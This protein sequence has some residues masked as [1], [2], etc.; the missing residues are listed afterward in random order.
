[1]AGQLA[2]NVWLVGAGMSIADIALVAH[3]RLAPEAGFF[4]AA[5][6]DARAWIARCEQALG[7]ERLTADRGSES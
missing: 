1:M 5:R 2:G 7:L 3:P 6:P 4:L